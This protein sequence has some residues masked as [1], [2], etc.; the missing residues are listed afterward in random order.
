MQQ[1]WPHKQSHPTQLA[2]PDSGH[3]EDTADFLRW[4]LTQLKIPWCEDQGIVHLQ[5]AEPDQI[6]FDGRSTIRVALTTANRTATTDAPTDSL[7]WTAR[8]TPW[9]RQRLQAGE[10]TLHLRPCAQPAA[11]QDLAQRLLSAYQIDGGQVH[12]GGCQLTDYPFLRLSFAAEDHGQPQLRH[13]FVAHDGSSISPRLAADL[14]LDQLECVPKHPLDPSSLQ[15]LIAAGRREAAKLAASADPQAQV[16]E[17]VLTAVIWVKHASG[18][19]QFTIGEATSVLPFSG[20]AKLLEAPPFVAPHSGTSTFHLAATDDERID[21][22][23]EIVICQHSG[24]RVLTQDVVR[25]SVTD[26]RVLAEFCQICP[27]SG[28]P[29]LE[30]SFSPC[31]I[32]RQS[33]SQ[34]VL[35]K[36]GC[37]ACRGLEKISPTDPRITW[38]LGEHTGLQRWS[39]WRLAETQQV[40]IVQASNWWKRLLAVIDKETLAVRHLATAGRFSS[41]W[42]DVAETDTRALLQHDGD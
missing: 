17:P 7:D 21:A 32:C 34:V 40:Y 18:Q 36:S 38:I 30:T 6:A 31:P 14:G 9:L 29:A 19:L 22:A 33:V 26:T 24:R 25:C 27:V 11:V 20:W 42:V 2:V 13:V 8:F 5:L 1:V 28:K 37:A 3:R 41:D 4:A 39:Q 23:T 12:L 10:S 16:A 15:T 35:A